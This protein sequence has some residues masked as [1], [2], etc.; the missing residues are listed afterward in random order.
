MVLF[1]DDGATL[2]ARAVRLVRDV[3]QGAG[4]AVDREGPDAAGGAPGAG[5]AGAHRFELRSAAGRPFCL[6]L[7]GGDRRLRLVAPLGRAPGGADRP[8]FLEELLRANESHRGLAFGL[9][10]D[11]EI[12]LVG[13]RPL[14]D[15]DPSE[16]VSLLEGVE[17]A[18]ARLPSP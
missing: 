3:L 2:L 12:V 16:L 10:G 7:L 1:E 14:A 17:P 15:L 6:E 5:R 8:A 11:D 4:C 9:R 18:A 13:E